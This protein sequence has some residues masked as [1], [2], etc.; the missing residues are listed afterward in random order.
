MALAFIAASAA[1]AQDE[2]VRQ[3]AA[4]VSSTKDR[5]V[6]AHLTD[7]ATEEDA[8]KFA[9]ERERNVGKMTAVYFYEPEARFPAQAL[10]SAQSV[11]EANKLL[12]DPDMSAW[13]YVFMHYKTGSSE[14]VDC[15]EP[16][17]LC[18]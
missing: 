1:H 11:S 9:A 10:T 4:F 13:R 8:R 3:A 6:I 15:A 18:R 5:I 2:A 14:F 7:E 16:N 17:D 12:D